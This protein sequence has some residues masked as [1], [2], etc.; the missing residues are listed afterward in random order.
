MKLD[1]H[2]IPCKVCDG[3]GEY[4]EQGDLHKSTGVVPC[5]YCKKTGRIP[6]PNSI[7]KTVEDNFL[8]KFINE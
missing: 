2:T 6:N 8:E 5:Y 1:N 3:K 4:L 7:K